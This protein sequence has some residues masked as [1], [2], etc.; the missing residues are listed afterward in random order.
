MN[1]LRA[2]KIEKK[3][4]DHLTRAFGFRSGVNHNELIDLA[5]YHFGKL[6]ERYKGEAP[7]LPHCSFTGSEVRSE[8]NST[9]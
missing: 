3:K 1:Q 4:K 5:S 8:D 6:P 7:A 2:I 9:Y